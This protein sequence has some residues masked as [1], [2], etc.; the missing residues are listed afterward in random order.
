MAGDG[1]VAGDTEARAADA[2]A[3]GAAVVVASCA[4]PAVGLAV[5][6]FADFPL[7]FDL[8]I[9]GLLLWGAIKRNPASESSL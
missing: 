4:A 8:A 2:A 5:L 3:S 6:F 7:D 1:A 9:A